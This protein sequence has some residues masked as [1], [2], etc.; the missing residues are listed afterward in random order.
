MLVFCERGLLQVWGFFDKLLDALKLQPRINEGD[1][2]C[3]FQ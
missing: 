2:N 3:K 1:E